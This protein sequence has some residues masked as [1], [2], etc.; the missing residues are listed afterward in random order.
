M[1]TIFRTHLTENF[2]CFPNA[3]LRDSSLSFRARGMLCMILSHSQEWEVCKTWLRSQTTEGKEAVASTMRELEEAGYAIN[4]K[5][6]NPAT[7]IFV[8][9]IWTFRDSPVPSSSRT[10]ATKKRITEGIPPTGNPDTGKPDSGL[11]DS[12]K[13]DTKKDYLE[14]DNQKEGLL[15]E[16]IQV[17]ARELLEAWN[18]IEGVRHAR[19]IQDG[20]LAS[21][22]TRIREKEFRENWRDAIKEVGSSPF[23][24]GKTGGSWVAN[25]DWFLRRGT[26][27]KLLEGSYRDNSSSQQPSLS[28]PL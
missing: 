2:T 5:I 14:E 28:G 10:S 17:V 25:I 3:L 16:G 4:H 24:L 1:I 21:L 13:P 27:T 8:K 12:G 7:G 22:K 6:R 9:S 26:V 20:R 11:P 19:S 23:L 18:S 15:S